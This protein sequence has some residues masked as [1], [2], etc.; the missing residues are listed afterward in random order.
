MRG[1]GAREVSLARRCCTKGIH[2]YGLNSSAT[3]SDLLTDEG[4]FH[5]AETGSTYKQDSRSKSA[6][7]C[8]ADRLGGKGL[9][10]LLWDMSVEQTEVMSLLH[11][12]PWIDLDRSAFGSRACQQVDRGIEL[13]GR[14]TGAYG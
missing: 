13:E 3:P 12:L 1:G 2:A 8:L 10:V 4:T 14:V 7:G 11:E 9:T 5:Q 6:P